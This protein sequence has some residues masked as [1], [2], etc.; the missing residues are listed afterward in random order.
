MVSRASRLV[1]W[2]VVMVLCGLLTDTLAEQ[3]SSQWCFVR[4]DFSKICFDLEIA[5]DPEKRGRGLMHRKFLAERSGMLFD[6]RELMS[7]GMWMKNTFIPLDMLFL[8]AEREVVSIHRQAQPHSVDIIRSTEP[9]QYTVELN[10]GAVEK[11]GLAVGDRVFRA[12]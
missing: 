9:V 8:N 4:A 6:F 5:D 7:I 1:Q 3:Q 11:F 2:L 12:R 10:G